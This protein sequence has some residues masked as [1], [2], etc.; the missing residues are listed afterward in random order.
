MKEQK[1]IVTH[2]QASINTDQTGIKS[3]TKS[4]TSYDSKLPSFSNWKKNIVYT[5][6]SMNS[7]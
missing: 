5:V 7:P 1:E 2:W 4:Q 3:Q 6:L